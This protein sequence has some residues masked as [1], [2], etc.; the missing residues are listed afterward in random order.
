MGDSSDLGQSVR[1]HVVPNGMSV[2][3]AAGTIGV[4]RPA[5]SNLLNGNAALSPEMAAWLQKGVRG[6]REAPEEPRLICKS[7]DIKRQG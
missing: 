7:L 2:T 5:L 6:R 1:E 4:G 3:E